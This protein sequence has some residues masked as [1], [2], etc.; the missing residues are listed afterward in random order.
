MNKQQKA[1]FLGLFFI[2]STAT[3]MTEADWDKKVKKMIEKEVKLIKKE[4]ATEKKIIV[5]KVV[6]I[7]GLLAIISYCL[8]ST[9]KK[10]VT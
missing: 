9:L 6:S 3:P 5:F 4:Q 1:F 8:Y 2:T 7:V 10:P